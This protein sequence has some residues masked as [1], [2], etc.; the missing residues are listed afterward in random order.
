MLGFKLLLIVFGGEKYLFDSWMLYVKSSTK[1]YICM[2]REQKFDILEI[3]PVFMCMWEE[4]PGKKN[5][6]EVE[7]GSGLKVERIL[8]FTDKGSC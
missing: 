3:S 8:G 2:K 1:W 5:D 4:A 6:A 7:E